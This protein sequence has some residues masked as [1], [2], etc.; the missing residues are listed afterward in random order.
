MIGFLTN[1]LSPIFTPMGVS[2]YDL[3]AYLTQL[4]G[5]VWAVL[6][7][8]LAVIIMMFAAQKAKKGNRHVVR[9]VSLLAGIVAIVVI[10]NAICFGPMYNNVSGFL[11]A[12][13]AELTA[14]TVAQSKATVQKVGEEGTVL[15]KNNGIL[16]LAKSTKL[17]VFGWASTNPLFGGTGSGSSDASTAV[18]ILQ[19]MVNAGFE[20]NT[21][22]SNMYYEYQAARPTIAMA[23]QDWTLP[24]PPVGVYNDTLIAATKDFSDTAVIVIGRSGG[25][26]ADLPTDMYAVIHGTYNPAQTVSVAPGN[27]NYMNASYTNNGN[28]DDFAAGESYLELSQTEKDMIGKV[29]SEFDKV[30]VIINA[31]NAMELGWVDEYPQ[32]G[33][34]LLAPGAGITGFTALGEIMCGDVNPSGRTVDTFVKDLQSTPSF[35]NFGNFAYTNV[36]DLKQ[37]IAAADSAYEGNLAFVNYVEGIYVGYKYY[38]TASDVGAIDYAQHVQYP[39]GYG[40]SYTTFEQKIENFKDEDKT[41]SF[42]VTVT[43]TGSVAGKDV[44]EVYFTPPYN[45]GG[46]EKASVNLI[47]FGKTGSIAPGASEKLSFKLNK[48]ELAAYDSEGVKLAGGGYILEAGDYTISLRADSHTVL[49]SETFTVAEDVDYSVTK[50]DSDKVTAVNQFEDFARG[51]FETLSRAGAFANY[52]ATCGSAP[53]EDAYIMDDATRAKVLDYSAAGYDPTRYDVE[54]DVMP[55]TGAKNGL[56][57]ADLTGKAYDD[58]NWDKLLD[59]LSFDD[60]STMINVGGWQTAAIDSVGKVAT[61]DCD[62]PAGLSNFITGAYGSAYPAEVLMAQT[63][64]KDMAYEIGTSMGQEYQDVNNYGWYGPAM[65]THRSAFAGR[66]FEYFSEDG[67]L[68]GRFAAAEINGAS[69]KG[70]YPYI[71]HYALNDQ[72]ANRCSFLLTFAPEQAMREIYLRP[73]ELA[74]KNYVGTPIAAMSAFNWIGTEPGCASDALLNKVL[75]D[76]WGFVGMVETDYN[77]SYGYQITDHCI[78]NGNDLMLGFNRAA[79]NVLSDKSA[80]AVLA[81]RQA[82]KNILYTIGNSGYYTVNDASQGGLTNMQKIFYTVDGCTCAA[83]LLILAIVLIRWRKKKAKAQ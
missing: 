68:A 71:K 72:E 11:N 59:Q 3:E 2:A 9:W 37:T 35:K 10:V 17:N 80:T 77:G 18:N 23:T 19:S 48:E 15:L 6:A 44:V 14:E 58:P 16:P 34:V 61:S 54:T 13:K 45:E 31:N 41:V 64:S 43:N 5:Y 49:A 67:V 52:D 57:L 76:E 33:A 50:R 36:D 81:M 82:C 74:V 65:N 47:D 46:I 7:I 83:V 38:E 79:T 24:E 69:T 63:W 21:G 66:N 70:L 26:G 78:R 30:V 42:D 27:F 51:N 56:K 75:R 62:G 20:I 60:M 32:I 12:S 25:E 28:Y 1:L 40:L 73:F 55:T 53:A 22:L 8:L 29:C 4:Q 39:F